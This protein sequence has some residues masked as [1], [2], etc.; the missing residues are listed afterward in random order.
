MI[1][2]MSFT[3]LH[4]HLMQGIGWLMILVYLHLWFV[5]YKRLR[6]ALSARVFPDAANQLNQ[7]RILVTI[8]LLLGLLNAVIG[9]SGRY[10]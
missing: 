8:N 9:A 4:V 6:K 10:W 3:P 7:I 2:D 1:T 5:P